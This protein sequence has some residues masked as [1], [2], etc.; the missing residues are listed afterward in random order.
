MKKQSRRRSVSR[1]RKSSKK[2]NSVKFQKKK[3]STKWKTI[4][5]SLGRAAPVNINISRSGSNAKFK[6]KQVKNGLVVKHKELL[7]SILGS[8]GFNGSA[9]TTYQLNPGLQDCFPW[10]ANIAQNYEQYVWNSLDWEYVPRC[11]SNTAGSLY[12]A[13]SYDA[14][15]YPPFDTSDK[16][17]TYRNS[18]SSGV[19]APIWHHSAVKKG[20]YQQKNMVRTGAIDDG[21]DIREY[22]IGNFEFA[23]E[24]CANT[25]QVGQLWVHYSVTLFNPKV[26]QGLPIAAL[27]IND[28]TGSPSCAPA[29]FM[30][31]F[32]TKSRVVDQSPVANPGL[33]DQKGQPVPKVINHFPVNS[34]SGVPSRASFGVPG[35]YVACGSAI[36]AAEP[37]TTV[38][39]DGVDVAA[40]TSQAGS[41]LD[42]TGAFPL[43]SFMIYLHAVTVGSWIAFSYTQS[44][45]ANVNRWLHIASA[46]YGLMTSTD[47]LS[48]RELKKVR[49]VYTP[50]GRYKIAEM[51]RK[52]QIGPAEYDYLCTCPDYE[53]VYPNRPTRSLILLDQR[54]AKMEIDDSPSEAPEPGF[55]TVRK[56]PEP[57]KLG[58]PNSASSSQS[59]RSK[60]QDAPQRKNL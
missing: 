60:S 2:K 7:Q 44:V 52:R 53:D 10:L 45:A 20:K 37:F 24:G 55:V 18:I 3:K 40:I 9:D 41:G 16:M 59:S 33:V 29:D 47:S 5:K 15:D 54:D 14:K 30:K 11:P 50:A 1:G 38:S 21:E 39:L 43:A 8:V 6:V 58:Q 23:C 35:K 19:W 26:T 17:G 48:V 51:Y 31:P 13:T 25:N 36:T 27:E 12:M 28:E 4:P 56:N 46:T 34:P 57:S 49:S 22:D 42:S 32:E